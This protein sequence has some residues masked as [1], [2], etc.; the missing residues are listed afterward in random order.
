MPS[1]EY[2]DSEAVLD[3]GSDEASSSTT[4]TKKGIVNPHLF[5]YLFEPTTLILVF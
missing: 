3:D 2:N 1:E 4:T 5:F